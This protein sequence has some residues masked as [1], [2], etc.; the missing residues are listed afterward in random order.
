MDKYQKPFSVILYDATRPPKLE[1]ASKNLNRSS[2][3]IIAERKLVDID[4]CVSLWW[5]KQ[6]HAR[7]V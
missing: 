3:K 4:L 7:F 5:G 1:L 6:Y 2:Q